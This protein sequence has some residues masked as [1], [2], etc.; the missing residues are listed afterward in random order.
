MIICRTKDYQDLSRK[1]AN[2]IRA[3]VLLLWE[4][5]RT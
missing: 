2:I 3:L 5:I 1:A 4:L